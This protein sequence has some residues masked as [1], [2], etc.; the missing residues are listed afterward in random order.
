LWDNNLNL[1][2][3]KKV[4]K[5][6]LLLFLTFNAIYI[7]NTTW[8]INYKGNILLESG[9]KDSNWEYVKDRIFDDHM[10]DIRSIQAEHGT[11]FFTLLGATKKDSLAIDN[12]IKDFRSSVGNFSSI[13]YS[14]NF[15][16]DYKNFFETSEIISSK[17]KSWLKS[18]IEISFHSEENKINKSNLFRNIYRNK[19]VSVSRLENK[20]ISGYPFG[21]IN[22]S[23]N[24]EI[25]SESRRNHIKYGVF[26]ELFVMKIKPKTNNFTN[27]KVDGHSFFAGLKYEPEGAIFSL[28]DEFLLKN[29]YGYRFKEKFKKYLYDHYSWH[30]AYNFSNKENAKMIAIV[31]VFFI[32]VFVFILIFRVLNKRHYKYSYFSYFLPIFITYCL[33]QYL[34]LLFNVMTIGNHILSYEYFIQIII[35]TA[36]ISLPISFFL[37]VVEKIVFRKTMHFSKL[38]TLKILTTLF[39]ILFTLFIACIGNGFSAIPSTWSLPFNVALGFLKLSLLRTFSWENPFLLFLLLLVIARVLLMILNYFSQSIVNAKDV[40]LS[41]LKE[42][43]S[44]VQTKLLQ[45]QIN[46]HFLYNSLNSIASL[47]LVDASK[48]QQMAYSLSDLFKYSI[49]RKGKK[50]GLIKDEIEMV[51]SYLSIEKIR[52]GE[53]LKYEIQVDETLMEEEIPLFLLQPLVENAVKHGVS[54]NRESGEIALKIEKENNTI[55]ITVADNGPDF[56]EGLVSGHG[57]QTVFDLLRLS[58]GDNAKLNWTNTPKKQIVISIP[59]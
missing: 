32:G 24:P 58:Y 39:S 16:K 48:T 1:P 17:Q 6:L 10:E 7:I 21:Y 8:Y 47:A 15:F 46:P 25:S 56:P 14:G 23:F 50:M 42:L 12:I 20:N 35:E 2:M 40:Q 43:N 33:M 3:M 53:R 13:Y 18:T 9:K 44:Q 29:L 55:I 41:R 37:W 19:D 31:S 54:K 22:F 49:N 57:L 45:S 51:E 4:L 52:F 30:Y 34:Y 59:K 38:L 5:I 26:R 28:Q 11:I 36:K 27:Y